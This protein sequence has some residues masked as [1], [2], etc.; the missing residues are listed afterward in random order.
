MTVDG[1]NYPYSRA[2]LRASAIIVTCALVACGGGTGL[3]PGEI[4]KREDKLR[5]RL[6]IDW[7]SYNDGDIQGSIDFFIKTLQEADALEGIELGVRNQVKAEAQSGIGWSFIRLQNL[8]AA[9]QAFGIATQL[10]RTNADAWVG[11]AGV[12]LAQRAYADVLQYTNNALEN[13][14]D[15]NSATRI[16]AAGRVLGHDA[17]DERHV[18]LMLAEAYFQL[19]RY[20]AA[21]RADP[22][23]AAA[24]VRLV[25]RN[26]RYRDPGQLLE[27]IS[28][29][30]LELQDL[31]SA[32]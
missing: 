27:K 2:L 12:A 22:N 28:E 9:A 4:Q 1:K 16:D 21:D 26:F 8:P 18:R 29:W 6:P 3:G 10:D 17:V 11:W 24:Q 7:N 13:D 5:E 25:D 19:G 32:G 31:V 14:P 15:Y 30:S 23:N 20:S